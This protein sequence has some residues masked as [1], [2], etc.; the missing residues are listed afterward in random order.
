[1]EKDFLDN[2]VLTSGEKVGMV[3]VVVDSSCRE[4]EMVAVDY[5]VSILC[6]QHRL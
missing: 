4:L 1:L 5:L 3:E 6:K 2:E